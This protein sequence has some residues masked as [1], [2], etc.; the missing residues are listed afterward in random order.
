MALLSGMRRAASVI[1]VE[2][3][4]FLRIDKDDFHQVLMRSYRREWERK[5]ECMKENKLFVGWSIKEIRV[6]ASTSSV[7]DFTSNKVVVRNL[8]SHM[9]CIY[10][11]ITGCCQTVTKLKVLKESLPYGKESIRML[12]DK[13]KANIKLTRYQR[14]DD[15][16]L[17]I[18]TL[19]PKDCFGF[20]ELLYNTSIITKEK[21]EVVAVPTVHLLRHGIGI[22]QF[23][24]NEMTKYPSILES[25]QRYLNSRNWKLYKKSINENIIA[26]KEHKYRLVKRPTLPTIPVIGQIKRN[27]ATVRMVS[28][29]PGFFKRK[30]I[31]EMWMTSCN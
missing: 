22:E 15:L 1:C 11:I 19:G 23:R 24:Q 28:P 5:I 6:A 18:R 8:Q 27:K 16:F 13:D 7:I 14:I 26:N 30:Q 2:T 12:H 29:A 20:G 3:A 10:I 21:V 31:K 17:A 25:F 9:G 4:E